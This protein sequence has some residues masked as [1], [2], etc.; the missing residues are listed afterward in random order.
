[1]GS[2]MCIRDRNKEV[3]ACFQKHIK[4]GASL[5][6]LGREFQSTG[7]ATE[8]ALSCVPTRHAFYD[9]GTE[10]RASPEDLKAWA[11]L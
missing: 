11:G 7:A 5:A 2:E 9:G 3:F 1:M 6:S 10:I 8:K 4:K